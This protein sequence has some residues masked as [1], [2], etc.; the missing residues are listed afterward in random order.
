M[1]KTIKLIIKVCDNYARKNST[2]FIRG[3]ITQSFMVIVLFSFLS[4]LMPMQASI[5]EVMCDGAYFRAVES[6]LAFANVSSKNSN[7][8]IVRIALEKNLVNGVNILTQEMIPLESGKNTVYVIQYDYVLGENVTIPENCVLEFDG[9]SISAGNGTNIQITGRNTFIQAGL[10]KIFSP[11]IVLAGS[12]KV[13]YAYPEWFGAKGDETNDDTRAFYSVLSNFDNVFLNGKYSID[14]RDICIENKTI[15][16]KWKSKSMIVQR[17]SN[18]P[19][20][21]IKTYC[22]LDNFTFKVKNNTKVTDVLHFGFSGGEY[23]SFANTDIKNVVFSGKSD[24]KNT[25]PFHFNMKNGGNSNCVIENVRIWHCYIGIWYE[26]HK[27][28]NPFGWITQ[29]SMKNVT[30]YNPSYYGFK[31]DALSMYDQSPMWC[32]A[33]YFENI[34]VDIIRDRAV[35]FYIGQGMGMLVNPTVFNDIPAKHNNAVGYSVEFAPIGSPARSKMV[36][37]IMGGTFEGQ[38]KNLDYAYMNNISN[39]KLSLRD[40]KGA[41][42]RYVTLDSSS[43]P[44]A[45][46]FN[47]FGSHILNNFTVKNAKLSISSDEFGE[48][49]KITRIDPKVEFF[50]SGGTTKE[51]LMAYGIKNGL[52]T[53]QTIAESNVGGKKSGFN[54]KSSEYKYTIDGKYSENVNIGT[55]GQRCCN[56][57]FVNIKEGIKQQFVFGYYSA[58][59]S[60]LEW[61]KIYSIRLMPGIVGKFLMEKPRLPRKENIVINKKFAL[62]NGSLR[63]AAT[64]STINE[65]TSKSLPINIQC[66][67]DIPPGVAGEMITIGKL[68]CYSVLRKIA[69]EVYDVESGAKVGVCFVEIDGTFKFKYN[70]KIDKMTSVFGST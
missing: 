5:D 66:E 51:D 21:L 46:D 55:D 38:V 36:T 17:N 14:F 24:D 20:A 40:K 53:L 4:L 35:G 70:M 68:Q 32:Y 45:F 44:D 41:T 69:L 2:F 1:I 61:V 67:G 42:E 48:Y 39:L 50:F 23:N 7:N 56:S 28:S 49:L 43:I 33:N 62:G 54:F 27:D 6:S 16:G 3:M 47:I 12:W 34:S 31:W 63:C 37:N 64:F 58:A 29:C 60:D 10:V 22:L 25:I 26:F 57:V 9:G 13:E 18:V 19:F 65:V 8:G 30:I 15:V 59:N 52:Y 11:N